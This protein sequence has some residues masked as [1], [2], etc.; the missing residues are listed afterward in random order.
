MAMAK[1]KGTA[2]GREKA[3]TNEIG[4]TQVCCIVLW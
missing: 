2:M 4:Q 3:L 1:A